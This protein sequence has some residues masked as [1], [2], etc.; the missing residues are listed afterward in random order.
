MIKKSPRPTP[1][2]LAEQE[3]KSRE[4]EQLAREMK[5]ER[6]RLELQRQEQLRKDQ[7]MLRLQEEIQKMKDEQPDLE[8][9]VK[10]ELQEKLG[11]YD[12]NP[13]RT[14]LGHWIVNNPM[15]VFKKIEKVR[16]IEG[17]EEYWLQNSAIRG[18]VSNRSK[19]IERDASQIHFVQNE[20]AARGDDISQ[21]YKS[22]MGTDKEFLDN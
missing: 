16:E 17:D 22:K 7:E 1:E 9:V 14:P 19:V 12:G 13:H 3:K 20:D 10:N 4:L 18:N 11:E 5:E 15:P 6:G 2:E 8:Q 21:G